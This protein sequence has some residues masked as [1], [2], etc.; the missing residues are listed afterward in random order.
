[1]VQSQVDWQRKLALVVMVTTP[2]A[3]ISK[4]VL[5]TPFGVSLSE[6]VSMR[7]DGEAGGSHAGFAVCFLNGCIVPI[8]LA[9]DRLDLM[10]S[11]RLLQVS[12][13]TFGSREPLNF[14]VSLKGFG[15][16]IRRLQAIK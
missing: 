5:V 10:A 11:G 7:I 15:A 3:G 4:G 12:V 13:V 16:A 14:N 2:V 6:G 9:R 1:M 8:E